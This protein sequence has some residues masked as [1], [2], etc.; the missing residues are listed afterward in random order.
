MEHTIIF[1]SKLIREYN[2]PTINLYQL[3][4]KLRWVKLKKMT[5]GQVESV[6]VPTIQSEL[7]GLGHRHADRSTTCNKK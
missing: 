5:F 7:I 1:R 4:N 3:K 6:T 2:I